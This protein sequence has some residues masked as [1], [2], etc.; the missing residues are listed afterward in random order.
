MKIVLN[1]IAK[2]ELD[3]AVEYYE[4]QLAGLGKRF[5]RE[6]KESLLR[7]QQAPTIW[8]REKE[9]IHRYLM[10][11]FPYKILYSI[12]SDHVFIIAIAHTHRR[13]NYWIDRILET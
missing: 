2:Q 7:I 8:I 9:E 6:V 10:H 5:K 12:E 3:D 11:K 4:L 1:A 13:P